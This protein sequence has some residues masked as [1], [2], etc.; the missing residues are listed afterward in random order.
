MSALWPLTG[1]AFQ[2]RGFHGRWPL[3][4]LALLSL[5][6]Q[7]GMGA[8]EQQQLPHAQQASQGN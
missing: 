5:L 1:M 4:W 2:S 8:L 3:A 7:L 6:L